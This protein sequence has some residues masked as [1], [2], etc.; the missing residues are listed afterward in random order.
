LK[1]APKDRTFIHAVIALQQNACKRL[2]VSKAISEKLVDEQNLS[3]YK[4]DI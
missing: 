4:V 2:E 1:Q 3:R